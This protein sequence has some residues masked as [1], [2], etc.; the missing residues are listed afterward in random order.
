[1]IRR[2]NGHLVLLLIGEFYIEIR[3]TRDYRFGQSEILSEVRRYFRR[4]PAI[5]MDQ[6]L[7]RV[8]VET[9]ARTQG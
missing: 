7:C 6:M 2:T 5:A 9:V 4:T 1:M 3:L 8:V